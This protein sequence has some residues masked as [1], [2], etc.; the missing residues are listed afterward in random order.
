MLIP[1]IFFLIV[2]VLHIVGLTIDHGLAF[3]T[4]PMIMITLIVLYFLEAG[5]FRF[6]Y[7]FGM[8]FSLSGDVLLDFDDWFFTYGLRAFLL[9]HI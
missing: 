9:V 7:F 3:E 6:L 1:S 8:V 5:K 2:S 4:K